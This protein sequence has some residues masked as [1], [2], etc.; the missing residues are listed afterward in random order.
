MEN[1]DGV[2]PIVS[3]PQESYKRYDAVYGVGAYLMAGNE[4][5]KIIQ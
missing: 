3:R 4:I 5:L 1:W 2:Q